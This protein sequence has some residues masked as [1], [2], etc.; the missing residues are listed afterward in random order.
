MPSVLSSFGLDD[1]LRCSKGLRGVMQQAVSIE[2]AAREACRFLYD[3]LTTDT[4]ARACVLVR[5]YK[6]HDYG[7]LPEDLQRFAR[8]LLPASDIPTPG[9]RCLT[10]MATVGD[11][12]A[13]NDRR[14]SQ[15]HQVIPLPSESVVAQAPMIAQLFR[16]L[17]VELRVAIAPAEAVVRDLG[18]RSYGVFHVLDALG[19]PY[20]PAQ[21]FVQR[22][23]V[24]SVVG[25]GGSLLTGDLFAI[26]LFARTRV[27]AESAD[28]FKPLALEVKSHLFAHHRT[29]DS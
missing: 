11:E 18:G 29:F 10:L 14:R 2:A 17:G 20:I 24:K 22:W 9:L 7:L 28:R 6:V 5:C 25:F 15:G 1:T 16:A 21:E 8:R 12:P 23:G 4:G 19:S 3:E 26:V 27:P 13:W